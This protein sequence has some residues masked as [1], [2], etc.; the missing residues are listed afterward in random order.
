MTM[1]TSFLLPPCHSSSYLVIPA[2][3]GIQTF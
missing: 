3:A 2:Q 1:N